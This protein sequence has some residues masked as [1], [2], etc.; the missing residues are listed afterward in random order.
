MSPHNSTDASSE[1]PIVAESAP[2][3]DDRLN[4]PRAVEE[5]L[6][7]SPRMLDRLIAQGD[8]DVV[9]IGAHRRITESS[10]QR[11]LDRHRRR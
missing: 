2:P 10:I 6:A 7:I 8:L 5:R 11:Y 9:L 1:A 4:R 3:P